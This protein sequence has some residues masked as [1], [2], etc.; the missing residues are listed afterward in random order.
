MKLAAVYIY[1]RTSDRGQELKYSLRSL[2]NVTNWNGEVYIC[3]DKEQWFSKKII[4]IDKFTRSAVK[5]QDVMNK[6]KAITQDKRVPDDFLFFND[7]FF[8]MRPTEVVPL[9]DGRLEHFSGASVWRKS[10]S[11]TRDYLIEHGIKNPYNYEVHAP[12]PIN[13]QN[14][15]EILDF[16]TGL[17]FRSIYGNTYKIGG[18]Q[19]KDRKTLTRKL[20]R[21][22]ILSTRLYTNELHHRFPQPSEFEL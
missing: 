3:G 20:L 8:V 22:E 12:I 21:G 11:K 17:S 15:L 13:K 9:Y 2:E 6:L 1:K 14:L 16:E 18:K 7:D 10:K 4:H 19:Y 5:Y